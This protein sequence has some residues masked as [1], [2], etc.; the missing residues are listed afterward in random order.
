MASKLAT[1]T[2]ASLGALL[3]FGSPGLDARAQ[4]TPAAAQDSGTLQR[5]DADMRRVIEKLMQLGAKPIGTQSVEETRRGPSPADAVK[6]LLRDQGKDPAALMAAMGVKKQD[7]TYPTAGT[8][9]AIRIYT[10]GNASGPLP[11]I[12]YIHGGGWVIADLD[13]YESSAMALAK[14]TGA[15]VASVEYRHAPEFRFPA[16]HEDTFAA[17]KWA[18]EN[19]AKFGGDPKRL[20]IA[21]ESAGGNMAIDVAIR[22]R[23]EKVQMPLHMLLVYPVAGTDLTTLSY[24]KDE[25]AVPLSKPAI[26]W[27]VKN[28]IQSPA[29]LQDPRLNVY[30]KANLAGLPPATII[31]AEIDPLASDGQLLAE[32]LRAAGVKTTHELYKGVTH[33]FFGMD[34]VVGDAAKAQDLAARELKAALAGNAGRPN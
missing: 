14:K 18:L 24:K 11:V 17:Y 5:A 21:G 28:T 16:A 26:E 4:T 3:A 8:T 29:D 32:K 12:V 1:L 6:A 31:N 7:M 13:T 2:S 33:E 22:A 23:D 20:A 10:P 25:H 15:I 9:Q 30:G 34:A 19:A 27:F